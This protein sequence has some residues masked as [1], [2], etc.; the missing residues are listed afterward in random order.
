MT[1]ILV[2]LEASS[3]RS[4]S[5]VIRDVVTR[6]AVKLLISF[7]TI[8]IPCYLRNITRNERQPPTKEITTGLSRYVERLY[9][10][11]SSVYE[12]QHW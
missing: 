9:L 1:V 3:L 12:V 6:Q 10:R 4:D 7:I 2:H 8:G 11:K 5:F